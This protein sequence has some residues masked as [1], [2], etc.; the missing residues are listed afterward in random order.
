MIHC[1]SQPDFCTYISLDEEE[2]QE[3]FNKH[4]DS[5]FSLYNN[6]VSSTHTLYYMYIH[7]HV[8]VL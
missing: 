8:L 1:P 6:V 2:T 3:A 4:F 7:V 5:Q